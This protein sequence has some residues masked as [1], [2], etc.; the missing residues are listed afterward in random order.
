MKLDSAGALFLR[1][2]FEIQ[3]FPRLHGTV[4]VGNADAPFERFTQHRPGL[5]MP[6][7]AYSYTRSFFPHVTRIG[8]YCSIGD[9][10]AVMGNNH[11]FDWASA[12]PVFYRRRRARSCNSQRD[13]FPPFDDLGKPVEIGND[14]WIGDGALLAHGVKLGTGS[15]IGARA[16]VTRDVPPYAIVAGAPAKVIRWRF[17]EAIV[18]RLLSSM[19]WNWPVNAWD[20]TDPR[21]VSAFL[22]RAATVRET[23]PPMIEDRMTARKLLTQMANGATPFRST[24]DLDEMVSKRSSASDVGD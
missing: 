17:E 8:R 3:F 6:L 7:G 9:A 11:P 1:Q 4:A 13:T 18:E 22:D 16:I 19:W 2:K 12:S 24:G 21:D 15:V 20:E 5:F 10:V 23:F 14:V